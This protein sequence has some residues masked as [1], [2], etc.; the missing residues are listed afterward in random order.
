MQSRLFAYSLYYT[1]NQNYKCFVI[2]EN[3]NKRLT[4]ME[5]WFSKR[6]YTCEV[7]KLHIL[8]EIINN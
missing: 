1:E 7:R 2:N 8:I 4:K 5:N 6:S 3:V